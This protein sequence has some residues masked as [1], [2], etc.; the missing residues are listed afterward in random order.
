ML[1]PQSFCALP[2]TSDFQS[3][4]SACPPSAGRRGAFRAP[5]FS[6]APAP[7]CQDM[8]PPS[9]AAQTR[10]PLQPTSGPGS[11]YPYSDLS[12]YSFNNN[13]GSSGCT[14]GVSPVCTY[15]RPWAPDT[16]QEL[17]RAEDVARDEYHY[18]SDV[19]PSTSRVSRKRKDAPYSGARSRTSAASSGER[20]GSMSARGN[21]P[22]SCSVGRN[23]RGTM[24]VLY[25]SASCGNLTFQINTRSDSIERVASGDRGGEVGSALRTTTP[26]VETALPPIVTS[27]C[28][29][30][31]DSGLSSARPACTPRPLYDKVAKTGQ[32]LSGDTDWETPISVSSTTMVSIEGFTEASMV[33]DDHQAK[34][35]NMPR[36]TEAPDSA[37]AA[38][39]FATS[40]FAL[41][42]APDFFL[43]TPCSCKKSRC[44]K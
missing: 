29:A 19:T 4:S 6:S 28:R 31:S 40:R 35:D 36:P 2:T 33:S 27:L 38:E 16:V 23:D 14:N 34:N 17:P 32:D 37:L 18:R 1:P 39:A 11:T 7:P 41:Q 24:P 12:A 26:P 10:P 13:V 22:D 3:S 8:L 21:V 5:S 42:P 25:N 30:T 43:R 20:S 44:L 15:A 9:P